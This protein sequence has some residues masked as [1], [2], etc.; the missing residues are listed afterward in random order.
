MSRIMSWWYAAWVVSLSTVVASAFMLLIRV[1][2]LV[3]FC[4]TSVPDLIWCWAACFKSLFWCRCGGERWKG[5]TL[6]SLNVDVA[7]SSPVVVVAVALVMKKVSFSNY[8]MLYNNTPRASSKQQATT[9]RVN[10]EGDSSW[11]SKEMFSQSESAKQRARVHFHQPVCSHS[12]K[13][14]MTRGKSMEHK[15]RRGTGLL[16]VY[17]LSARATDRV[18]N[19]VRA[20]RSGVILLL[21]LL[22]ALYRVIVMTYMF[23][24]WHF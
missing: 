1:S 14:T 21:L 23:P 2:H 6:L 20:C 10:E 17:D 22:L 9:A 16:V 4:P 19:W 24:F 15:S 7:L 13:M 12:I 3:A 5:C 18:L 8:E 11:S